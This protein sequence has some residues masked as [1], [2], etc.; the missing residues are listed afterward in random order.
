MKNKKI[1]TTE[2][3]IKPNTERNKKIIDGINE[4]LKLSY[5]VTFEEYKDIRN[6]LVR[7]FD[8]KLPYE[9]LENALLH[10]TIMNLIAEG[11]LQ[12][13][14]IGPDKQINF[15][16]NDDIKSYFIEK[17]KQGSFIRNLESPIDIILE[18]KRQMNEK[19]ETN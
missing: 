7:E 16:M 2:L 3:N 5:N 19:R 9:E 1:I 4:K 13:D 17:I 15:K 14:N 6:N 12:I 10:R 11:Y 8:Y 18:V